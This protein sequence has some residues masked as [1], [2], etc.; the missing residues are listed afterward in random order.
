MEDTWPWPLPSALMKMYR[1]T[2]A[3][4]YTMTQTCVFHTHMHTHSQKRIPLTLNS[5]LNL[6]AHM[7]IS[8]PY[9]LLSIDVFY[10]HIY[11]DVNSWPPQSCMYI[12][13]HNHVHK[14]IYI[15]KCIMI[16]CAFSAQ[17]RELQDFNKK[18]CSDH[19]P[20]GTWRIN[21]TFLIL[22]TRFFKSFPTN[23]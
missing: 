3:C 20:K 22:Y 18:L 11:S 23:L 7:H 19:P 5:G 6:H 12:H 16:L 21:Q 10:I 4:T 1:H 2:W 15:E 13:T 9:N 8:C 17:G 14:H